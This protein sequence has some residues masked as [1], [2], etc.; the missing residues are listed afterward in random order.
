M[1][2]QSANKQFAGGTIMNKPKIN[3]IIDSVAFL[4]FLLLATTGLIIRHLLP[5]GSGQAKGILGFSRHQWGDIHFWIAIA[6]LLVISTHLFT[7]W[8]WIVCLIKGRKKE[9]IKMRV[10][11]AISA[12]VLLVIM[13][14]SILLSPV[15]KF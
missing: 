2:E 11:V 7:H 15:E 5:P 8:E 13:V 6:I 4:L 14:F 9:N 10:A 3:F 12:V 1:I